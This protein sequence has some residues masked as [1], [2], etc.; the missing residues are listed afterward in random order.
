MGI[1]DAVANMVKKG[2]EN[3]EEYKAEAENM[4]DNELLS[5]L[6]NRSVHGL[7]QLAYASVAKRR[8]YVYDEA[9]KMW[10]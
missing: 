2:A 9:L 3:L 5:R 6:N 7:R 1:F 8:G 4:S 10:F